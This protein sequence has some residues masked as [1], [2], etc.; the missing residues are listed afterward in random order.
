[1]QN[2]D[3]RI[4]VLSLITNMFDGGV[5]FFLQIEHIRIAHK[6]ELTKVLKCKDQIIDDLKQTNVKLQGHVSQSSTSN[7]RISVVTFK[8]FEMSMLSMFHFINVCC[9]TEL[10]L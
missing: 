4:R 7:V 1:M 5:C 9:T 8:C 3:N 6:Q 10:Q 2:V